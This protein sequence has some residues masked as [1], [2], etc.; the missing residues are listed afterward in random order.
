[1]ITKADE[2]TQADGSVDLSDYDDSHPFRYIIFAHAGSDW[3]SDV[4]GESPN[5]I[6]TF[7][8]TLGEPHDLVGGGRLSECS[9]IPETTNTAATADHKAYKGSIAAALYHEFGHALGLVDIYS[10]STGLPSV[11]IWD[12]MDSGTNLAANVGY[13]DEENDVVVPEPVV[14][15]L[16]PSL[17]AWD[18]WFLGWVALDEVDNREAAYKLP[19]VQVPRD[20]YHLYPA[21][22]GDFDLRHPQVLKAGVSPREFFL[23]EN[24]WVPLDYRETPYDEPFFFQ[25]DPE[26]GV[27]L[28]LG[29]TLEGEDRN[30]GYYDFFLPAG[31]LLVWQVN[32]DRIEPNLE[33]NT[34]NAYGDGL[35][36]VEADGIQDIGVLDAYVLGFFGSW[37]DPFGPDSGY[38]EFYQEGY[39]SSRAFDHSWTGV[40][41]HDIAADSDIS[42]AVMQ[43][44]ATVDPLVAGYPFTVAPLD[45]VA[46]A[47]LG[48]D[49]GPRALAPGS[50]TPL[51]GEDEP[52]ICFADAPAASWQGDAYRAT[53]FALRADGTPRYAAV[54][55]LPN[56]AVHEFDAV[57]AGPPLQVELA[58]G[59]GL[60]FASVAG[61]VSAMTSAAEDDAPTWRW[62]WSEA[63]TL[64]FGPL[65]EAVPG[66]QDTPQRIFCVAGSQSLYLLDLAGQVVGSPLDLSG[67]AGGPVGTMVAAPVALAPIAS[68]RGSFA[69]FAVEGWYLV[70][71]DDAGLV[72]GPQLFAYDRRLNSGEALERALINTADGQLLIAF[73]S[74]GSNGAWRLHSAGEADYEIWQGAVDEALVAEPAVAD[75][76]GNGQDDLVLVTRQRILAMQPDGVSLTGYPV[77]LT[78]LF[79]VPDTTRIVGPLVVCD[80]DGDGVNEVFFNSD[81]GHLFGLDALG[82]LLARTPFLW[83]DQGALGLTVGPGRSSENE[84]VLWLVSGGGRR[85]PPLDRQLYNGRIAGYSLRGSGSA[86]Q[87]TS[88]WLAAAGGARRQGPEGEP[89]DLGSAA[90]ATASA[91]QPIY[92]PNPLSGTELTVRFY[93]HTSRAAQL[94]IYNLEGEQV[95]AMVIPVQAQQI[96]E[97]PVTL[98]GLASGLYM[99]R[100]QRETATGVETT[101]STLAIER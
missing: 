98:G 70:E 52:V 83:G 12:L 50:L 55:D 5:D 32:M 91:A 51:P 68:A 43:F 18:K 49:A 95:L 63:D 6:P 48:G 64:S 42:S 1:M 81:R 41:A 44:Q 75:L 89:N 84:R 26:T 24:R 80:A 54:T 97:Q 67:L 53:L 57:L 78:N 10:T 77:Q 20:E 61:T 2:E 4:F 38:T 72:A 73:D 21:Q 65:T 13:Y 94:A 74:E 90:P 76:D 71:Q 34:V 88:E 62:T 8:V 35:R 101:V 69:I 11:G 99:C 33:W 85:G 28:Y 96:N 25:S 19:A 22:L 29:G 92:Y 7:F 82:S 17:S 46:A 9:V 45:S 3:Q 60:V 31:G 87:G 66:A 58:D 14:G 93:S 56:A 23:L 15:L 27:I 39:P 59:E 30:T 79:P 47:A 100:L 37:R 86:A 36:L 40:A 16:P